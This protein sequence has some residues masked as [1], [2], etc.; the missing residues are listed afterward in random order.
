[1]RRAVERDLAADV[2]RRH[3]LPAPSLEARLKQIGVA[4]GRP[5]TEDQKLATLAAWSALEAGA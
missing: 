2:C 5:W 1:M 3:A 4:A